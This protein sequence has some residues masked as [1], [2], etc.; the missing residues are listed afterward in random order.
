MVGLEM[1]K[2]IDAGEYAQA[3]Q[4]AHKIKSSAG[5]IGAESMREAAAELQKS[6]QET[7]QGDSLAWQDRFQSILEQLLTEI[8]KIV[9]G[10]M[11]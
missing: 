10:Q 3:A 1:K 7:R 11:S 8:E 9:E 5:S 6:L 2:A 4:I